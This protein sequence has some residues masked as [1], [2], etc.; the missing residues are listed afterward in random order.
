MSH[1]KT[2]EQN[3]SNRENRLKAGMLSGDD[4]PCHA[5]ARF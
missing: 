1:K 4:W 2:E 3:D 5:V